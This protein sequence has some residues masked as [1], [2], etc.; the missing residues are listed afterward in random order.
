MV[1]WLYDYMIV[2]LGGYGWD[3]V[4]MNGLWYDDLM[5]YVF[6]MKGAIVHQT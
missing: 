3:K 4:G 6:P 1:L 5:S 2:W